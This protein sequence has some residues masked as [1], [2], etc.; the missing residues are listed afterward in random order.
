MT[1]KNSIRKQTN[2]R[3]KIRVKEEKRKMKMFVLFLR[4]HL[5]KFRSSLLRVNF[6]QGNKRN[7]DDLLFPHNSVKVK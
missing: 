4:D 2:K 6:I 3:T 5:Y 7:E 1:T